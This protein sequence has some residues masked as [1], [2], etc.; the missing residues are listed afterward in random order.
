MTK[1][2]SHTAPRC[3]SLADINSETQGCK[4]AILVWLKGPRAVTEQES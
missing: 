1:A 2:A 4:K 3:S